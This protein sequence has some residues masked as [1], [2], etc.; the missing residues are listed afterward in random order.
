MFKSSKGPDVPAAQLPINKPVPVTPEKPQEPGKPV[1]KP[2][3]L[4]STCPAP[5]VFGAVDLSQYATQRFLDTM[6]YL[7]VKTIIRYY[8]YP[9]S[10]TLPQKI[11]TA[12]ELAMIKAN[13]F[14]F[15]GVFQHSNN[16]IASFTK[17]R[18]IK[19]AGKVLELAKLWKQPKGSGVYFGVDFDPSESEIVG[20]IED[21]A[22][23]FSKIIRGA[24]FRVGVYGSGLTLETLF[25][26][27]YIEL[28]W[29]S[30]STGFRKS[31]E[32]AAS[33]KWNLKQV[34]DRNCGGINCDFDYV[35]KSA[36]FGQWELP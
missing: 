21:Y 8:D 22:F 28:T 32:Y 11:P 17:E 20:P 36:D 27:G 18:G 2:A 14:K 29:L 33:G 19:D 7:G 1:T 31:K 16:R 4:E 26:M 30:M 15:C 12:A 9:G 25:A 10:P 3:N 13:G 35:G 5:G 34:L 24:G 23:E 6:K